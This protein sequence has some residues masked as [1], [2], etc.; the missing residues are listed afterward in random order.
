MVLI[1]RTNWKDLIASSKLRFLVIGGIAAAIFFGILWSAQSAGLPAFWA[2]LI[3]YV[4]AF[5]T[6]YFGHHRVTFGGDHRHRE[7]M[8]RYAALQASCALLA[9]AT[10]HLLTRPHLLSPFEISAITTLF[11]GVVAYVG[12]RYWVF[13]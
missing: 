13:R 9:A 6:G 10:S 2:G 12:S 1:G 3:A 4:A 7:T 5:G 8:P 11:M